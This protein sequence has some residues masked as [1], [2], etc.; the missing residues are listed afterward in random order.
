MPQD[1]GGGQFSSSI[2]SWVLRLEFVSLVISLSVVING[3][4]PFLM[5]L[6]TL[7]GHF[8]RHL[9]SSWVI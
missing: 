7:V 5:S 8:W 2:L 1:T 9:F 3:V 6:L 4:E